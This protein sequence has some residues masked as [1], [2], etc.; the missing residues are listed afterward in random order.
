MDFCTWVEKLWISIDFGDGLKTQKSWF[1]LMIHSVTPMTWKPNF[2]VEWLMYSTFQVLTITGASIRLTGAVAACNKRLCKRNAGRT[3]DEATVLQG[4]ESLWAFC[5]LTYLWTRPL[6][7]TQSLVGAFVR[8]A[9]SGRCLHLPA[10]SW[11]SSTWTDIDRTF[12]R[13]AVLGGA[14]WKEKRTHK[15]QPICSA[16]QRQCKRP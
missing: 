12:R 2:F 15:P 8:L 9:E 4:C 13:H 5:S 1:S 7:S 10:E 14:R 3:V 16:V 11:G 6:Y